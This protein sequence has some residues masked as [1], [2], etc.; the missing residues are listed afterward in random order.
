MSF[1]KKQNIY[2]K[3][4]VLDLV[5]GVEILEARPKRTN[6]KFPRLQQPLEPAE[7]P[8]PAELA[9]Q[10]PDADKRSC[11]QHPQSSGSPDYWSADGSWTSS[12]WD[13]LREEPVL[14]DRS[15]SG[16]HW[17]GVGLKMGTYGFYLK[18]MPWGGD[19]PIPDYSWRN[20]PGH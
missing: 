12:I 4:L 5:G 1:Q 8:S 13:P 11:S 6:S 10:I 3:N 7:P 15:W 9:L 16:I 14:P 20:L 2:F 18:T 17:S 19:I